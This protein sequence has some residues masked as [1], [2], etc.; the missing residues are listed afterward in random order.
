MLDRLLRGLQVVRR[1]QAGNHVLG[2][3]GGQIA[4]GHRQARI[5]LR[6]LLEVS[7]RL[8]VPGALVGIHSLVQLVTGCEAVAPAHGKHHAGQGNRERRN[9]CGSIHVRILLLQ[10]VPI[11]RAPGI[12]MQLAAGG[13]IRNQD[14]K[15]VLLPLPEIPNPPAGIAGRTRTDQFNRPQAASL[16]SAVSASDRSCRRLPT[17]ASSSQKMPASRLLAGHDL[18]RHQP[19][20]IHVRGAAN[21]DHL[22]HIAEVELSSPL[23]NMMRSARLA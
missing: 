3:R 14:E 7:D 1:V 20:V 9:T 17:S 4:L 21:I 16:N 12:F 19:D 5:E 8:F 15:I 22:G 13:S 2:Q 6:G 18:R 10:V 11:G 23:T